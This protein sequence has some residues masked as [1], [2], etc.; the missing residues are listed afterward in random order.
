[1][2]RLEPSRKKEVVAEVVGEEDM[3]VLE[4]VILETHQQVVEH[5]MYQR[6]LRCSDL[7]VLEA[8]NTYSGVM[9]AEYFISLCPEQ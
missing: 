5:T 8:E 3:E 1:V 4:E 9:V 6:S 7:P 2:G